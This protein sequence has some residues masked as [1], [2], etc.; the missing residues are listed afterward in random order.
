MSQNVE[1]LAGGVALKKVSLYLQARKAE[2]ERNRAIV[3][4]SLAIIAPLNRYQPQLEEMQRQLHTHN[5]IAKDQL[6][7]LRFLVAAQL[8]HKRVSALQ[9]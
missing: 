8:E 5:Q 3:D 2:M 1:E 6:S 9:K 7:R 4:S